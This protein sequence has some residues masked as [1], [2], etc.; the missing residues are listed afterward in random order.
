[1]T[2]QTLTAPLPT[3][4]ASW[5][6]SVTLIAMT[7]L[8][9]WACYRNPAY[10][11]ELE[12]GISMDLPI[13]VGDYAGM[14]E[15]VTAAER[16]ILPPD[17]GFAKKRYSTLQNDELNCQIVMSGSGRRSIHKPEVCLDGQG[18][19]IASRE[20]I[21]ITLKN[22]KPLEAMLLRLSKEIAD[23]DGNRK[24]LRSL[25]VYYFVG[26]DITTPH[27]LNRI[28]L[29]SWD[30]VFHGVNHRWAF[31]IVNARVPGSIIP[32]GED[33]AA[34][35]KRITDFIAEAQPKLARIEAQPLP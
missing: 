22:G 18:W 8:T 3:R 26:K 6:Q 10:S 25:F 17:T 21:P 29:T 32:G 14:D 24:T 19:T 2:T 30:R 12:A 33:D 1:M 35:L 11:S 16:K 34:T 15:E 5:W 20:V 28:F 23:K 7:A 27:H 13:F 9:L 31:V 4:K